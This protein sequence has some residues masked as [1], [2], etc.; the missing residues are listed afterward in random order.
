[1]IT[2]KESG[3][4]SIKVGSRV[5][6]KRDI[7]QDPDGDRPGSYLAYRGDVLEVRHKCKSNDFDWCVAHPGRKEGAGFYVKEDEIALVI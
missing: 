2:T 3:A 4:L 5:T 6:A 1:M 7:Y